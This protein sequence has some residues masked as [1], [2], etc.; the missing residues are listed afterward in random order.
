MILRQRQTP[1]TWDAATGQLVED[2]IGENAILQYLEPFRLRLL[3]KLHF[4][5]GSF[6]IEHLNQC[7]PDGAQSVWCFD[8]VQFMG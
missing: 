2:V 3:H 1:A 5:S 6:T 7:R 4:I 8:D